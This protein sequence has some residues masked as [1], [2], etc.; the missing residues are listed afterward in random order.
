MKESCLANFNQEERSHHLPAVVL[1]HV[2]TDVYVPEW[3]VALLEGKRLIFHIPV[4]R[5]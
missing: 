2:N 5:G 3:D 1:H 4:F